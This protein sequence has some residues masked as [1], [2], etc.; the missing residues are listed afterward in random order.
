M[1]FRSNSSQI[2]LGKDEGENKQLQEEEGIKLI[3]KQPGPTALVRPWKEDS[4]KEIL[5]ERAKELIK[6]YTKHEVKEI[7]KIPIYESFK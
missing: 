2:I 7:E 1:L 3:P 6:N 4:D 5:I